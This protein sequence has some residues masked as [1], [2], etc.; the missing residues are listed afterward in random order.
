MKLNWRKCLAV[1]VGAGGSA[2]VA[3]LAAAPNIELYLP[4]TTATWLIGGPFVAIC[5]AYEYFC[6]ESKGDDDEQGS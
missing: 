5:W 4:F 6:V 1:M 3:L 2:F